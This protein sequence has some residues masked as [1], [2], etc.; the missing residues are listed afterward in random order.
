MA[1]ER[2]AVVERKGKVSSDEAA[3]GFDDNLWY[4]PDL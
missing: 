1:R 4:K 2:V 3:A